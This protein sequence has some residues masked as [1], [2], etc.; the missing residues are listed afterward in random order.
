LARLDRPSIGLYLHAG[1]FHAGGGEARGRRAPEVLRLLR[2]SKLWC[3]LMLDEGMAE[4]VGKASGKPVLIVPDLA[5]DSALEDTEWPDLA[6]LPPRESRLPVVGLLGHLRPTKGVVEMARLAVEHPELPVLFLF[7]GEFTESSFSAEDRE[8]IA[9]AR[10]MKGR[11]FF[12]EGRIPSEAAYNAFVVACDILWA[13]YPNI[14]HSSNTLTKAALFEK[15]VLVA[16]GH[17]MARRVREFGLGRV[18]DWRDTH[19]IAKEIGALLE[20]MA[21]GRVV[22]EARWA[23]YREQHSEGRL[24]ALL[25]QC[26]DE[27]QDIKRRIT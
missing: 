13:V 5:D 24:G 18:V 21:T 14:P 6:V 15:P 8:W 17:L 26:L 2:H 3:I 19:L 7:A 10:A 23:A 12:F 1:V 16:E 20:D 9:R 25:M 27:V 22:R 4:A 11:V